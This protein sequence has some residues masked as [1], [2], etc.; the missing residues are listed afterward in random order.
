MD[1]VGPLPV[2]SDS[3]S[4]ILTMI[5]RTTRWLEAVPLKEMSAR[6]CTAAFMASWVA[7]FG[8][9]ATLTSDRGTQFSSASWQ[10]LCARLGIQ[11][12]MTTSYH[13]QAYGM[14]ER[15]HRQLKDA[16]PAREAGAEWPEHLLWVLLGLRAAPKETTGI[17]SAQLVLG[18]PLVL[19]GEL[20]DVAEAPA[21]DFSTQL[22]SVDPPPTCQP[23]SYAAVA[24]SNI[25]I[26][27]QLQEA[28]FVYV[29]RGG[30]IPPLALVYS[31]PYR[32]LHAGPKVFTL[33]VGVTRETVSVDRL[34]PHTGPLPV[35]PALPARRGRPKK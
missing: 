17:S 8:V 6:A 31:G 18:Q 25:T 15:V 16:L 19:P 23:R 26:S 10:Q 9:P 1:L 5:N 3:F 24:A 11:H 21:G 22:A 29:L 27:K 12:I 33:E 7:R 4:Y 32:V 30:T 2:T 35:I 13:P 20:K 34:K 14:V 28:N